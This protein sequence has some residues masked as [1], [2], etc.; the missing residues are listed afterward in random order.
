MILGLFAHVDYEI[1]RRRGPGA[2][3]DPLREQS[4]IRSQ[5][6]GSNY[7]G[8]QEFKYKYMTS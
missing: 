3:P 5:P 2:R 7:C 6:V 4:K 8:V 1:Q